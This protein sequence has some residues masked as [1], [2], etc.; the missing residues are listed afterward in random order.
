MV[1]SPD[2]NIGCNG[3]LGTCFLQITLVFFIN[4]EDL[5]AETGKLEAPLSEKLIA[6]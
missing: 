4:L 3:A 1:W 2:F 5:H 6:W